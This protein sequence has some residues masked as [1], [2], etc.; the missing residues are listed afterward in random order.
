MKS[1]KFK[2]LRWL[3]N[4]VNRIFPDEI[5]S[6]GNYEDM[7]SAIEDWI[8]MYNDN[9]KWAKKCHGK[10]LNLASSIASEFAR[11]IM[12]EFESEITGSARA[13]WLNI[14]YHNLVGKLRRELESACAVGGIIFKPYVSNGI[15]LADCITQDKF[16]P[17]SYSMDTITAAVFVA[18]E[19]RNGFYYTRLEKHVYDE[20][21][22]THTITN[23]M[24]MSKNAEQLGTEIECTE[25]QLIINNVDRPLFAFWSVP[26]SNQID[27][28]SPLGVSIFSRAVK[29]MREADLQWDRY[30]WE[31]KGGELAVHASEFL[32][33]ER[34]NITINDRTNKKEMPE[35]RQR[36]FQ[37]F[38]ALDTNNPMYNV[39]NPSLRDEAF[40]R[41]LDRILRKIEFNCS[42][43][44]GTI[45]DPQ[46]VDKTAEEIK[47]SKQRSYAAVCDMQKSLQ[48]ALEDY[49]YALD[50]LTTVCNLAPAGSYETQFNW[51]D[52]VL[53]DSEKEQAIRLQE[54]NSGIISKEE[55]LMWR[56]GVT[57]EQAKE[58]IPSA[59]VVDFFGGES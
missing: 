29:Q 45:S 57:E 51:G 44:Y 15:I 11:L 12:I 59:G 17:I 47:A 40:A 50:V 6:I 46:N 13:D 4:I 39:F 43:A 3:R 5:S 52:G 23:R 48:T 37:T 14:Q 53:E 55:Y 36:L 28:K 7:T 21:V 27:T 54:V 19:A 16:I 20:T 58:M 1:R 10:T 25:P 26:F 22:H 56:Y 18:Q 33:R 24:F 42:L 9:P 32:L 35:T 41:G 49:I 8:D 38:N 30:L 34:E 31:Y 2:F